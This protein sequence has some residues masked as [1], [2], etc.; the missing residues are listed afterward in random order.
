M[1]QTMKVPKFWI[2]E[3]AWL[4]YNNV[5]ALP[6]DH[7]RTLPVNPTAFESA[8][9]TTTYDLENPFCF[10][11]GHSGL[12]ISCFLPTVWHPSSVGHSQHPKQSHSFAR[13]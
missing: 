10:I 7:F 6:S 13:Y 4:D 12:S 9:I 1:A 8:D 3:L 11:L 5:S 2:N